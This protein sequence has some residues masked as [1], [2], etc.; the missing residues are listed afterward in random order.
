MPS[1]S[2]KYYRK[3]QFHPAYGQEP[4]MLVSPGKPFTCTII[5]IM[6]CA[7]SIVP[8][9]HSYPFVYWLH[10]RV[11]AN[12]F[13][14]KVHFR[15]CRFSNE[16]ETTTHDLQGLD[17]AT[18]RRSRC[19]SYRPSNILRRLV[20]WERVA[21]R[22]R[23]RWASVNVD[24]LLL[25]ILHHY[26]IPVQSYRQPRLPDMATRRTPPIVSPLPLLRRTTH[27]LRWVTTLSS[28]PITRTRRYRR[29]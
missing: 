17:L 25:L 26:P 11:V 13:S 24:S 28:I 7:S 6:P 10:L 19:R 1:I 4:D 21:V 8:C 12:Q 20:Q 23:L 29:S 16:T 15:I 14:L 9:S 22:H 2:P 27:V 18:P 3:S 5:V